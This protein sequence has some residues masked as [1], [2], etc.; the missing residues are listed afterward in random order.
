VL[1]ILPFGLLE[2]G[3]AFFLWNVFTFPCFVCAIWI[4]AYECAVRPTGRCVALASGLSVAGLT[5]HPL[6]Q[7][8]I[9]GQFNALLTFLLAA[10]WAFDRRGRLALSGAS[11]GLAAALKLF[12]AFLCLYFLAARRWRALITAVVVFLILNIAAVGVLGMEP[13]RA[14]VTDV[15]PA[16]SRE[17][18]TRWN[19]L[20]APA[21]WLRLFDPLPSSRVLPI[22]DSPLIGRVLALASQVT[23]T[24]LVLRVG[25]RACDRP[26]RDRAFASAVVAMLLVSP[27]TWPHYLI[28]LVFPA[29]F[30]FGAVSRGGARLG[31]IVLLAILWLPDNT[32]PWVVLGREE[33]MK[34]TLHRHRILSAA[35]NVLI[36]SLPHYALVCIFLLTLR[37]SKEPPAG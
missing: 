2:H 30:L 10:A 20:S 13:C 31:L 12:P 9:Q 14:Y 15:L 16:V 1:L 29:A 32:V 11:I 25:W 23:I 22:A 17:Y 3:S 18:S 27:I 36:G 7:Q 5:C 37:Y 6:Y 4:A 8:V 35:E 26:A 28:M 24:L 19:N 34:M 33:A 21:Y